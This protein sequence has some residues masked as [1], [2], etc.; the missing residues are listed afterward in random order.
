MSSVFDS[1][2]IEVT[3]EKTAQALAQDGAQV[4]DVREPYEHQAGR[5]AGAEHIELERLASSADRIDRERPVIF[6]CRL[7][8]RS[9][10]AAQAFRAGGYEAYTM[11]GGLKR[12]ADEGRPLEPDGG[13]VADH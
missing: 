13:T 5:I 8:A 9:A 1:D 6:H 2:D 12:W 3:P 7:G 11:A 10:M 4:I